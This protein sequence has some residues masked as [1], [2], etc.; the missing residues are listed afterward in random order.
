MEKQMIIC[1]QCGEGYWLT[2]MTLKI[3][4][5]RCGTLVFHRGLAGFIEWEAMTPEGGNL[6]SIINTDFRPQKL[7]AS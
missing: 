6:S 3:H 2:P 4:C 1:P 7:Q 5:S